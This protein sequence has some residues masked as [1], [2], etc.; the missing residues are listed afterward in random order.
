VYSKLG[1]QNL[2]RVIETTLSTMKVVLGRTKEKA[3]HRKDPV[4]PTGKPKPNELQLVQSLDVILNPPSSC[5]AV[6]VNL[7]A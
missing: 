2:P 6:E 5:A 4:L 7:S 3:D 1:S